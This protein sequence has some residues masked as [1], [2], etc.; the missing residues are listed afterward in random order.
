MR[1]PRAALLTASLFA[2]SAT[3]LTQSPDFDILIRG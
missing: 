3:T 2:L 1:I